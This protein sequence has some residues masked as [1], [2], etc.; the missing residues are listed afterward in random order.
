MSNKKLPGTPRSRKT[1]IMRR[2][3]SIETNPL[4]T[5]PLKELFL[6]TVV[7]VF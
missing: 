4:Y 3:K 5:K 6:K 7:H 2:K 1:S